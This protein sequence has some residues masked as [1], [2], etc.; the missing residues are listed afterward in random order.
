MDER[1]KFNLENCLRMSFHPKGMKRFADGM[2]NELDIEGSYTSKFV[3]G[4]FI[5]ADITKYLI[6]TAI[7]AKT[8]YDTYNYFIN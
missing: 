8:L 2:I 6:F 5:T 1:T 4:V 3:R 7:T